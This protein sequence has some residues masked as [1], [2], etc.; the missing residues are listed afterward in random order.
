MLN[1]DGDPNFVLDGLAAWD[2][3]AFAAEVEKAVADVQAICFG[4]LA[5]RSPVAAATIQRVVAAA[6]FEALK[7]FDINLRQDFYNRELI[8][9]SLNLA[10]VLKLNEHELTVLEK[11]FGLGGSRAQTIER[12]ADRFGL[13]VIALT[14]G[15]NGSLLFQGGNWSDLPGERVNVVDT[16]GA[17]DSFSAALTLGLLNRVTL[18][19]LHRIAANVATHVCACPGATPT[20]PWHLR[21]AFLNQCKATRVG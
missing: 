6:P 8:E 11:M 20:L 3:I 18:I 2:F 5:Q 1:A 15:A 17:G 7:I 19:D 14:R 12:L 9:Q 16:V 21:S 10:N 13:S 4:S